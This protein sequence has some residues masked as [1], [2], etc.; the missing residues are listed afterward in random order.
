MATFDFTTAPTSVSLALLSNTGLFPSPLIA[1]AQTIDRGG[2]K[3]RYV[4]NFGA[5][6]G[7][8][9]AEVLA[10]IAR[11]K[12]QAN[13]L[14]IPVYDNPK[15]GGY[16]GNPLVNGGS[17]TGNSLNVDGVTNKSNWIRAGDYFS[18]VVN[19]EH[20]LKMCTADAN[21]S[22]GTVTISFEPPLRASPLNNATVWVEDGSDVPEGVFLLENVTQ[23]WSSQPHNSSSH[24]T[25]A[26]LQFIEDVFATQ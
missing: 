17:Q 2:A 8:R 14:R 26:S 25:Q 3:W 4:L 12:G 16:G 19:G 11:C 18:V 24:L 6:S 5:V 21:S 7:D 15:R 23:G 1:S 9:R 10:A 20:E 13:R 22:G